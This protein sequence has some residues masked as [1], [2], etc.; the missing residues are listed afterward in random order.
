MSTSRP[1]R[2]VV[3]ESVLPDGEAEARLRRMRWAMLLVTMFGYLFFYSGRLT[4]GFAIPGIR[5]ETGLNNAT[6]GVISTS[7]LWCYAAGQAIN[8]NLAD[9]IG[10]R[11]IMSLGALGSTVLNWVTS[12]GTGLTSLALPWAANGYFQAMGWASGGR[13][14][15]NWWPS[16]TRGRTYAYY[17]FAAGV[18]ST[19]AFGAAALVVDVW[20]L[21]WRWIFRLPVLLMLVGGV[22]FLLFVRDSPGQ[23]GLRAPDETT[24]QQQDGDESESSWARYRA[25]LRLPKIWVTGVSI[26]FQNAARYG[27]LVWVPVH[28]FE[29][30]GRGGGGAVSSLWVSVGLPIGMAIG[31]FVNGQISDRLFRSRRDKPIIL[32]MV[33]GAAAATA[34]YF[35]PVERTVL[36]LVMIMLTGLL[37]YGPATSF[38][39]L[40]P[41]LAGVRRAGTATGVVN[42]FSYLFAGFGEPTIGHI[43]DSSGH[44]SYIFVVVAVC[45]LASATIAALIRR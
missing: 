2:P 25:V 35:I 7:M 15:N 18:G 27:L 36:A 8:G 41:D 32:F 30:A 14:I 43:I 9:K 42:F 12:L 37:V 13:I 11:R 33:L 6:L 26:G 10:G 39:A 24:C 19:V 21:D 20:N 40:C 22:V 34:M 16:S 38:W 17:T 44:T 4:F 3:G 31:A 5:A 1:G 29:T 23:V 28:F 45:C